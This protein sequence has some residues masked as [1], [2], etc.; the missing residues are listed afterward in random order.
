MVTILFLITFLSSLIWCFNTVL[1]IV[2]SGCLPQLKRENIAQKGNR[3]VFLPGAFLQYE[4]S[5]SSGMSHLDHGSFTYR[6]S[7]AGAMLEDWNRCYA[8]SR[9]GCGTSFHGAFS[10]SHLSL[11]SWEVVMQVGGWSCS[12]SNQFL[13]HVLFSLHIS[14]I[15]PKVYET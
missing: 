10:C 2:I 4:S 6:R 12:F 9:C 15:G 7:L 11:F 13:S 5:A 1:T 8:A 3:T 14:W